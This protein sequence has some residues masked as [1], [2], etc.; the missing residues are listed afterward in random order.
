MSNKA[1]NTLQYSGTVKLSQNIGGK[2]FE[3]ATLQ[4]AG[5]SALFNFLSDCLIG[6][7]D[8]ASINRPSKIL[9]L[10]IDDDGTIRRLS[11]FI[12]QTGKPEKIFT[13]DGSGKVRYS[14]TVHRDLLESIDL[15]ELNNIGLYT[16]SASLQS[17]G[18]YAALVPVGNINDQNVSD[19]SA[20]LLDWEL[21]ITNVAKQ[22]TTAPTN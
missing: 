6:D 16:G 12:N 3:L 21:N 22:N 1:I 5:G 7:F 4:N 10:N 9:L 8:M 11:G 13:E 15:A 2:I 18:E 14:F 17:P 19:T 20:I